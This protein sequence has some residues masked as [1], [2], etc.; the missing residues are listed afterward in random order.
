MV[1]F[2]LKILKSHDLIIC[3]NRFPCKNKYFEKSKVTYLYSYKYI[4]STFFLNKTIDI[5]LFGTKC[6]C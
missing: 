3:L 1:T 6:L 5:K 2:T 4:L